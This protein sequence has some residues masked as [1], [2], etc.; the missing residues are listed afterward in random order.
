MATKKTKTDEQALKNRKLVEKLRNYADSMSGFYNHNGSKR[1]LEMAKEYQTK[2]E[3]LIEYISKL[4][5]NDYCELIYKE[6]KAHFNY[7]K[8]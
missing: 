5:L 6:A 4:K 8:K 3:I 1:D 7:F 2:C